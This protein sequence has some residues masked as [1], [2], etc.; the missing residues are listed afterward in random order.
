MIVFTVPSPDALRT[1]TMTGMVI[2]DEITFTREVI[3]T[4]GEG[5]GLGFYGLKG[6]ATIVVKRMKH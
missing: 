2:G 1:I 5:H 6:P 3:G 4:A